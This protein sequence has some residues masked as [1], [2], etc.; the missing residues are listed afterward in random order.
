M[1][2]LAVGSCMVIA[3][4]AQARWKAPRLLA[5]V[6]R[7]GQRSYEVYLTHI[8]IVIGL[9]HLFVAAGK[10]LHA[11]PALFVGVV[12]LSGMLGEIAARVYSEPLN[13]RLRRWWG[14]APSKIGSVH[15]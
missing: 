1:T 8:F 6:L 9:F 11:V 12:L 4:A 10:P 7:V 14:E 15:P 13:R 2:I 3:V 5:P